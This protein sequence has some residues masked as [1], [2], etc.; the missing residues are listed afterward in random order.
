M[1]V[2]ALERFLCLP[3][4][5][6]DQQWSKRNL[7]N[8]FSRWLRAYSYR[9]WFTG[10]LVQVALPAIVIPLVCFALSRGR[11]GWWWLG[12]GLVT[13]VLGTGWLAFYNRWRIRNGYE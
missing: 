3:L 12:L 2:Q 7:Y 10:A 9:H 4:W 1:N 6:L 5:K 11:G 13:A 8:P